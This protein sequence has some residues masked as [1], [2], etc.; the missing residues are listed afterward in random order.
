MAS[1]VIPRHED[2]ILARSKRFALEFLGPEGVE[3]RQ[4]EI[5]AL[6]TVEWK[7]KTLYTMRC[8][9]T[10]GKGPHTVHLPESLLWQLIGLTRYRCVYHAGD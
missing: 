6:P 9:G 5:D 8:H 2:A 1:T 10:R 3:R 4:R 7:G